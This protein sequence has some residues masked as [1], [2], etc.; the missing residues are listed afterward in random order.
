MNTWQ[1]VQCPVCKKI[2]G[3]AFGISTHMMMKVHCRCK[4][5]ILIR[6]GWVTEVYQERQ[7]KSQGSNRN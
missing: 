3:E 1:K 5:V 7:P 2:L 4:R 6:E